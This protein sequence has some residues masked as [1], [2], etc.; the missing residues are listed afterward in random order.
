MMSRYVYVRYDTG[1]QTLMHRVLEMFWAAALD[2]RIF[3][4]YCC[5]GY[6]CVGHKSDNFIVGLTNVSP[7]ISTP[8]LYNYTLCGQYPGAVPAA[9]TVSLFCHDN[10]PLFRYVIVQIPHN[11]FLVACEIEVLVR[12]TRM[13]NTNILI[14]TTQPESCSIMYFFSHRLS[15]RRTSR[16]KEDW[17]FNCSKII[18]LLTGFIQLGL[19]V[20][21]SLK[22]TTPHLT[23]LYLLTSCICL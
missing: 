12:G 3:I 7:N 2:M 9:A 14:F 13:S 19:V 5:T 22:C 20:I 1:K 17:L 23:Q 11:G 8:T 21:N 18:I 4:T 10:L 16:W 15:C 6:A